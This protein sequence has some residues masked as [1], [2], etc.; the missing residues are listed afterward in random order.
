V[1]QPS[2][3][4]AALPAAHHALRGL[5]PADADGLKQR[6]ARLAPLGERA[7]DWIALTNGIVSEGRAPFRAVVDADLESIV[8][9]HLAAAYHP[10]VARW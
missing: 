6:K 3:Q 1:P 4:T 7:E 5:R 10:K 8:A 9:K 2:S